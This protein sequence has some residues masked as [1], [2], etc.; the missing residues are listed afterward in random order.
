MSMVFQFHDLV[1]DPEHRTVRKGGETLRLQDL[2]YELLLSLVSSAP[3][4]LGLD[5]I[6]QQVWKAPHVTNDTIA[7]RIALLRKAL[8]DDPKDPKYIR[9]V[10]GAGYAVIGP[11]TAPGEN[12]AVRPR[13][14][15]SMRFLVR[16]AVLI[17]LV[18]SIG[19]YALWPSQEAVTQGDGAAQS[20]LSSNALLIERAQAQLS[21]HQAEETERALAMLRTAVQREP[22][23][24]EARLALSF[25][26]VTSATKF[27]G[28]LAEKNEAEAI[29]RALIKEHPENSNAWSALGYVL[30]SM[31]R[32]DEALAA[33]RQSI[34]LEPDNASSRSSA[35]HLLL[36]K[37]DL[38]QALLLDWE[39]RERGGRSKYS[40]IQIAQALELIDHPAQVAWQDQALTL[41]PGQAVVVKE[42]ALSKLRKG[43]PQAALDLI[44]T[45]DGDVATSPQLQT[46]KGRALIVSGD[47]PAARAA[48]R[49]AGWRGEFLLAAL[50]GRGGDSAF[51]EE[52]F[53]VDR[54]LELSGIM[55]PDLL[56]Q[57]AEVEASLGEIDKSAQMIAL[58]VAQGWRDARWLEASPFLSEVLSD[59]RGRASIERIERE[60]SAQRE[61]IENT[62]QLNAILAV[63]AP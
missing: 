10:R 58:A 54:R 53:P 8:G 51:V 39:A 60:L 44:A 61:L 41:N 6:A 3:E 36:L 30:S 42:I 19:A 9:T 7:Q 15:N 56:V 16:A 28:D 33:Y 24:V 55:E 52:L 12:P 32:S 14:A 50:A 49:E 47:E 31:G 59:R 46:L 17:L 43:D 29:A 21:L 27:R 25:A 4:P 18:S 63:P 22:R 2:T 62:S 11:V 57:M 1:I 34:A 48:L 37:G 13:H 35:A 40:E 5:A 26:L 20:A 23:S 38:Q 45:Y